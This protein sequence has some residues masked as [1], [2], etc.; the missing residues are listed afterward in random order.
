MTPER[1]QQIDQIFQAALGLAPHERTAYIDEVCGGD[2][3]LRQEVGSLISSDE[4]GLS[5][6]DEP[7]FEMAARVL[8]SDEPGLA[9]GD[10]IDR[11]EVVSLL[12]SGGMGEVYLA[13]DE[14]LARTIALKLLPAHF[15]Q[16]QERLRRFQQEARAASALNHPNIL[17]IHELGEA[18]GL[19]FIAT[20]FV[21]GETLRERM[22]RA[23]FSLAEIVDIAIQVASA[24]A[25]AHRAGI[26]HRDIKPENIMLRP[27]GYVK[28]LDFGLAKLTEQ[29]EPAA[30]VRTAQN[31]DVSS[32]LV[33]GTV[34]Y[35]SPEQAR[36]S[37]VDARSD[38]FSF[39][40]M[41]Y[42]MVAGRLP[43][44]G[45]TTSDL[46]AAILEEEP[47]LLTQFSSDAPKELQHIVTKSLRK[48]KRERYQTVA[49]LLIDLKKSKERLELETE[50]HTPGLGVGQS[51]AVSSA[52]SAAATGEI[53]TVDTAPSI[54][55]LIGEVQRHK[56]RATLIV[57]ILAVGVAAASFGLYRFS[58]PG[59]AGLPFQNITVTRLTASGN[60]VKPIIS[61][62]GKYVLYGK[63]ERENISLWLRRIG[64]NSESQILPRTEGAFGGT[65]FSPDG[66]YVYY[67][68]K[69]AQPDE[70][71]F[72]VY[73]IPISGGTPMRLL[74]DVAGAVSTSSDG[75][76]LA[77][78][79]GNVVTRG[80]TS[81]LTANADGTDQRVILSRRTPES[82]DPNV[83]WN[84]DGT[85]LACASFSTVGNDS[86]KRNLIE[87]NATDGTV[88]SI[89]SQGWEHV[90]GIVWLSNG[91]GLL[92]S[93]LDG[94][95][96]LQIW[97]VTYPTGETRKIT[98]DVGGYDN[99]SISSDCKTLVSGQN[100]K[101]ARIW[102]AP[103][104]SSD[105]FRPDLSKA[106][107]VTD[108]RFDGTMGLFFAP[109]GKIVFTS[110][111]DTSGI[112]IMDADGGNRK[113]L[114]AWGSWLAGSPDGRYVV[115]TSFKD[116]AD[117][118]HIFRMDLDGGNLRQLTT[119]H[120]ENRP[121]VSHDG[122]WVIYNS[123]ES[124]RPTI[125]KV[126]IDGG[127]SVQLTKTQAQGPVYSPDGKSIA[128]GYWAEKN[129]PRVAIIPA[130]GG[131]PNKTI[132]LASGF[133]MLGWA[134]DS[135]G[136]AIIYPEHNGPG[137]LWYQ[138]IDGGPATQ[139]TNFTDDK[140]IRSAWSL[141]GTKVA[142]VRSRDV[143]DVV[144][145]SDLK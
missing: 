46:I 140:L 143:S 68:M 42:E 34:K 97:Y 142:F 11:Y 86:F 55:H 128:Y 20:E 114:A 5:F 120:I 145:I 74:S 138:P 67:S 83:A 76:R 16:N 35:M 126:S 73:Q 65:A 7:A 139:L 29:Y 10:R 28:V 92:L 32:G 103:V 53:E 134:P 47:P 82:F 71:G 117:T 106:K 27:D 56:I 137:N 44:A 111:S 125:G 89:S 110:R 25:A 54:G 3:S 107:Q 45:E 88:K 132:R 64:T 93:A 98:N 121:S 81:L 118:A 131:E 102:T 141:D 52:Q 109:D 94:S 144:L 116:D 72:D 21:E 124:Q 85:S 59:K 50:L 91:S 36:G 49:D 113:Q 77:Y 43:F 48:D 99:I 13:H 80:E 8:A 61:P 78:I 23:R 4:G 62:D 24:L 129:E 63:Q 6:I 38:I 122:K 26:V 75:K 39:G 40:V 127:P 9:N 66:Q 90:N 104:E 60:A 123:W 15:T 100:E 112:W 115:F 37:S 57:T 14:K 136:L 51:F 84:P 22:K 17:T 19:Q 133:L 101:Q 96:N 2:E 108:N 70:A 135:K 105:S 79:R 31:V 18:D 95:N 58:K 69:I 119:G 30:Q 1:Y 130:N 41:L 12:G 33:M 87:V